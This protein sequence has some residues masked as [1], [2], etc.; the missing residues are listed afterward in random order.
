MKSKKILTISSIVVLFIFI[1]ISIATQFNQSE[2]KTGLISF[3]QSA[4]AAG[5]DCWMCGR[6]DPCGYTM[7]QSPCPE[8]SL[9]DHYHW[10]NPV[11][12]EETCP[13]SEQTLCN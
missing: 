12:W 4:F 13:V 5:E 8:G 1:N 3:V 9:Y 11:C 7:S 6:T 2:Q 10:C